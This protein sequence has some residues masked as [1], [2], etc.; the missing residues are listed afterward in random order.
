MAS[1]ALAFT[2]AGCVADPNPMPQAEVTDSAGIRIIAYDLT[3][4]DVPVHRE[5]GAH[6]L[7]IGQLNGPP[8]YALSRIIDV[9]VLDDGSLVISD[10]AA[11]ALRLYDAAGLYVRTL[12]R[13][14][15]GPGEFSSLPTIAGHSAD[16]VIA[17]DNRGDR[18]T[19]VTTNGTIVGTISFRGASVGRP[20]AMLRLDNG[21]YLSR[22]RWT[23]PNHETELHDV[24]L[25]LDSV[26]VEL[27]DRN[28][29]LTDTIRV[30]ADRKRARTVLDGGDGRLRVLGFNQ[31][32]AAQGI[33]VSDGSQLITGRSDKFQIEYGMGA[34]PSVILRVHGVQHP[35]TPDEIKARRTADLQEQFGDRPIPPMLLRGNLGF[36]PD[37]L[38]AFGDVV[39]SRD[40]DVW[41]SITEFDLSDGLDWLVFD[42]DGEM[43]GTVRTPPT[44]HL[45]DIQADYVVGFVLDEFDVP[46]VRRYPLLEPVAAT[47]RRLER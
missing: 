45:R 24:R 12:G 9:A 20:G 32:Y 44:L 11:Q 1:L 2:T 27:L 22:S 16:T 14:G 31:P 13:A 3:G 19:L 25:E 10:D 15:E 39:V 40:G 35:A 28:G 34:A 29:N 46:Y 47:T 5:L 41:V 4:A 7:E 30:M 23:A 43:R 17:F 8:E 21:G 38:P 42:S 36:L 26:V 6:D 37:R 18:I 33:M